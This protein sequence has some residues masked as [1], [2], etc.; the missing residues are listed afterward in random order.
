V[1]LVVVVLIVAILAAAAVPKYA[2]ALNR[3]RAD[4]AARRIVADLAAA[5]ARARAA[6]TSLSIVFTL[7]PSGS[8]YQ[9]VGMKDPDR[10]AAAYTVDLADSPYLATLRSA[11]F[12]GDATIVYNGYGIPDSGGS[13]VV[14]CGQYVKTI[15]ID[16]TTGTAA[17]Q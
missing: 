14:Y 17:I 1:E 2:D 15:T 10:P 16:P 7:P 4:A 13:I 11:S 6:S 8:R 5:Q 12:G 9:V 3:F